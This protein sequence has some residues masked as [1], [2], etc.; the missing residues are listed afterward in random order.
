MILPFSYGISFCVLHSIFL[1]S[2]STLLSVTRNVIG[3]LM[4][5]F[6]NVW[7][8]S[9]EVNCQF[10]VIR[11][12]PRLYYISGHSYPLSLPFYQSDLAYDTRNRSTCFDTSTI[13]VRNVYK[14]NDLPGVLAD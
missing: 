6:N 13:L 14:S 2:N 4:M 7:I 5:S 8:L 9:T 12:T 10:A 1:V 3:L 11:I